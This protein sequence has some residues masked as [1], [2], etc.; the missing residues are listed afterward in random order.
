[1][2]I[3][4]V[5]MVSSAGKMVVSSRKPYQ[6]L[7]NRQF[8]YSDVERITNNFERAIGKGG[9]GTVYH[10]CLDDTQ[11][12]VKMLSKSSFQGYKQFEAEV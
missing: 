1:M 8:T 7:K 12:A 3:E 10:G 11:V 2:L 5:L 9:F 4:L 6:E